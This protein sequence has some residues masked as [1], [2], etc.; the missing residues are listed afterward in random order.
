MSKEIIITNENFEV[1]VIKS[2]A[3][4]LL[5]FWASWCT[6]C[7]MIAPFIEQIAD[8]Y[9]GRLKVGKV[10]VDEQAGLAS[11]HNIVSIP[12][13]TVYKAGEVALQQAGALPKADI[14]KLV[15]QFL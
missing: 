13:L 2:D 5:D 9:D 15:E 3:P 11:R 8:E 6:P 1:E 12:T 4:V 10:N 14:V 7:K